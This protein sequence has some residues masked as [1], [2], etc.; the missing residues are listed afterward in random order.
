MASQKL[1]RAMKGIGIWLPT[2]LLGLLFVMQ[3]VMKLSGMPAWIERFRGYG[4]P[5]DFVF[6]VGAVE[7]LG[8]LM[9][10][11]PRLA[12]FGSAALGVVMLGAAVTHLLQAE[13]GNA[14]FT[15]ILALVFGA[16]TRVRTPTGGFL[17][18]AR[19]T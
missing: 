14:I 13:I 3:G 8:G 5:D 11:V 18:L 2:V 19:T 9:L 12:R 6:V 15:F 10:F 7:L 4:Y 1:V 17:R 16:I